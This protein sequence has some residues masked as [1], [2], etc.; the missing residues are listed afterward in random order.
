LAKSAADT[1][2]PQLILAGSCNCALGA[3]AGLQMRGTENVGIVWFDAHGDFNTPQTSLSGSPDGMALAAAVGDCLSEIC[4]A[5]GL[6][7][8]IVPDNVVLAAARDLDP[9]E[10]V[11]L[12]ESRLSRVDID[13]L[14]PALDSL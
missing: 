7:K 12:N 6:A 4:A 11:R 5:C 10:A 3:L 1:P 13:G 2:E 9:G 14:V 8:S